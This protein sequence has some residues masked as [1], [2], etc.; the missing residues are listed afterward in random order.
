MDSTTKTG[1]QRRLA[2]AALPALATLLLWTA[3]PAAGA[4]EGPTLTPFSSARGPEAPAPWRFTTLPNK[5]A[6]R[7][8]VVQQDGQRV[9]RVEADQSYGNLV[10]AT[11]TPLNANTTL[12]WRWRVE[13]FVQD[14]DLRTR[15][16]DDGAA[17]VCVFFDFPVDRLPVGERT[18]LALARRATGEQVPS[19]ALCY[20]WDNKEAKG[21]SLVNAFTK[22]MRMVVLESGPAARPGAWVAERRNLLAD[23]K[24]AFG[25]EA[26]DT[27]PDVV[28][29]AI[30]A[31]ADNTH[32]HGVAYFSDVLLQGGAS[33]QQ[34]TTA[35]ARPTQGE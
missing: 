34:A 27:M 35:P 6:T 28:A 8:E 29:V 26:G 4:E 2:A 14:A 19:E 25:E 10:H 31:D 30:A 33:A 22:R 7:F 1:W 17:K 3:A 32:G 20:V 11:R 18:R 16:G 5:T 15:S 23:Y 13:E 9:L 24:R 12:A 21:S